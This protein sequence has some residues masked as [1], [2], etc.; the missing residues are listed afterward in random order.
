MIINQKN[1]IKAG[2]KLFDNFLNKNN[3]SY[4]KSYQK[5]FRDEKGVKYFVTVD[6]YNLKDIN[7]NLGIQFQT[8]VQFTL[9]NEFTFDVE[10]L[11]NQQITI[12]ELEAFYEKI[13]NKMN[14]KYYDKL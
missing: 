10:G 3:D 9:E 2:Y 5:E 13:W 4:L 1:L 8:H 11:N 14:C 12:D 6:F 7:S